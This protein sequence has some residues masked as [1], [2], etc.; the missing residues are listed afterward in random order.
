M[1]NL[2]TRLGEFESARVFD[3]V[4]SLQSMKA[5]QHQVLILRLRRSNYD[6]RRAAEPAIQ[7][8]SAERYGMGL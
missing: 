6:R 7:P 8:H 1:S 5:S 2:D 4:V 3:E